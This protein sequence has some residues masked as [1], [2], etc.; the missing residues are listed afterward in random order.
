[1]AWSVRTGQLS[2]ID[3][4]LRFWVEAGAESTHTDDV[5]GL[6]ALVVHDPSAL[7]VAEE[8]GSIVGS[9]IAAWDGWRGSIY[10]LVVAPSHRRRGLGRQLLGA[11]DTRLATV[12]AVRVQAIVVETEPKAIGFWGESGWERQVD[13]ARFVRG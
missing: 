13:R 5:A 2:D 1:V 4:V 10:R 9:V 11:A 3:S 7:I 8:D 12:G 6:T